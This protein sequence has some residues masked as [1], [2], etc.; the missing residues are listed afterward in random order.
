MTYFITVAWELW[1]DGKVRF[2]AFLEHNKIEPKFVRIQ[3][4]EI[5]LDDWKDSQDRVNKFKQE[6]NNVNPLTVKLKLTQSTTILENEVL[7]IGN[8]TVSWREW[9]DGEKRFQDW[10]KVHKSDPKY[11]TMG[12]NQ[13]Q[14]EDWKDSQKRVIKFKQE[15]N[16]ENPLNVG[17]TVQ[18]KKPEPSKG[19]IP[20]FPFYQLEV[21]KEYGSYCCGPTSALICASAFGLVDKSNFKSIA[22]ELCKASNTQKEIGTKPGNLIAGFNKV[23]P[24]LKMDTQPF[25]EANIKE[26]IEKQIPMVF[27]LKVI[28]EF[29]YY[30]NWGHYMAGAGYNNGQVGIVDPYGP[31]RAKPR[32]GVWWYDFSILRKAVYK[33][34]PGEP[35]YR[36]IKR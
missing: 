28:T 13:I 1:E 19:G 31:G 24:S 4:N 2:Q 5:L 12:K 10:K 30:G 17:L 11:V 34:N 14:L 32:Y 16:N 7:T 15:H 20:V 33:H 36:I 18:S 21:G 26:N 25:S 29:G 9:Q 6:N 8:I 27:N 22:I 3:G 35:L 23:F